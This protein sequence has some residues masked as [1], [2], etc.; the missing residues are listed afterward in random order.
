MWR[1]TSVS[2]GRKALLRMSA[3]FPLIVP[4]PRASRVVEQTAVV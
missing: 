2:V 3:G 1:H 4:A